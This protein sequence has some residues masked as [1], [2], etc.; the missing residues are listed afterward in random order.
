MKSMIALSLLVLLSA[1]AEARSLLVFKTVSNCVTAENPE[2]SE[3]TINVQ[4]AQDGQAQMIVHFQGDAKSEAIQSKKIIPP[5]G[6]AGAPL[7]YTGKI[8]G[9]S[10]ND[11]T[12]AIGVRPVKV[13]KIV[14]KS[15][16]LTIDQHLD[17][18]PMICVSAK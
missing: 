5:K 16:S 11:I 8:A 10:N 15:A 12:L 2:D 17:R 14:G 3:V 1:T 4:E 13:G 18:L 9:M 7:K 6:M